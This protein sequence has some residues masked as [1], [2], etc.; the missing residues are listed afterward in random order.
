[1]VV[2]MRR[3]LA[4]VAIARAL[5][6]R[7]LEERREMRATLDRLKVELEAEETALV[8][9][10]ETL[11]RDAFDQRVRAF[12]QRVRAER[13]TAQVRAAAIQ[14]RYAAAARALEAVARRALDEL[15][16]ERGAQIAF[17]RAAVLSIREAQD[18]TE[19]LVA[20]IDATYPPSSVEALLPA[21]PAEP[22]PATSPP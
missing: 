13:R 22:A 15:V 12:D 21:P 17:D 11:P 20:R 4:D 16:D 7:E 1:V 3:A 5:R 2:D 18:L 6:A 10:R 14:E 19:A 8:D 9:L